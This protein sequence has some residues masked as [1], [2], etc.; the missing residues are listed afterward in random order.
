[1]DE[2][3]IRGKLES[4]WTTVGGLFRIHAHVSINQSPPAGGVPTVVLVHGLVISSLYMLPT[5]ERLA[6]FYNVF[7][8]DLPGFGKSD[9]PEQVLNV[10]ELADALGAWIDAMNLGPV[11]LVGNSMGCQIIADLAA[12][13][14]HRV[15]AVVLIAATVDPSARTFW[16]QLKRLLI[17]A[18]R[19][20]LSLL[21]IHFRSFLAAGLRRSIQTAKY[22]LE[23]RIEIN[24]PRISCPALVISGTRDP[25]SPQAWAEQVASLIPQGRLALIQGGS[26]ALNYSAPDKVSH[27]IREFTERNC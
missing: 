18:T 5:A 20:P 2:V 8:P 17:D 25:L 10:S 12:R 27:L 22:A 13:A 9:K 26:H 4:R 7:A 14:P 1:V 19:E 6:T 21:Y 11:I 24:L 23:D 15:K 3:D 16:K